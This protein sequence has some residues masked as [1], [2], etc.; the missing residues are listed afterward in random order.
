M[1]ELLNE[2]IAFLESAKKMSTLPPF[3]QLMSIAK[4]GADLDSFA[5]GIP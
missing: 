1:L 5:E 3:R 4:L 2:T